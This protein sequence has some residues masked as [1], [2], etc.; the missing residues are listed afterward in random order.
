MLSVLITFSTFQ[1]GCK[2]NGDAQKE[3]QIKAEIEDNVNDR[4]DFFSN[5][6]GSK[7]KL[8]RASGKS[9]EQLKDEIRE[10]I[11]SD[12]KLR[13]AHLKIVIDTPITNPPKFHIAP[14]D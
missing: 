12:M 4:I 2:R 8:E 6:Y 3:A 7:E 14:T 5:A 1:S 11:I 10:Q 9:I 13:D